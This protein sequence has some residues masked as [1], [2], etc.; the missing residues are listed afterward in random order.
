MNW[1]KKIHGRTKNLLAKEY[2][3]EH[4]TNSRQ[5]REGLLSNYRKTA[6]SVQNVIARVKQRNK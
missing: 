5:A 3:V 4:V 6:Q 2:L 1:V